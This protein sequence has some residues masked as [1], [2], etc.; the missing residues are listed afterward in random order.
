MISVNRLSASSEGSWIKALE[1]CSNIHSVALGEQCARDLIRIASSPQQDILFPCLRD[2]TVTLPNI[3]VS[4][5]AETTIHASIRDVLA[6][7]LE[8]G[9]PFERLVVRL[10]RSIEVPDASPGVPGIPPPLPFAP[11]PPLIPG[12]H[13]VPAASVPHA[14]HSALLTPPIGVFLPARPQ[15]AFHANDNELLDFDEG[16]V[17]VDVPGAGGIPLAAG[18]HMHANITVDTVFGPLQALQA[19][20]QQAGQQGGDAPTGQAQEPLALD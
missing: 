20:Q 10:P 17:V 8:K 19:Q 9:L 4:D 16:V 2:L 11:L 13:P 3:N 1:T 6:S 14:A 18:V 5:T 7:R 12:P 15:D